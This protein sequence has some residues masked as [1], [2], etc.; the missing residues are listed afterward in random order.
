M[1][2]F[3]WKKIIEQAFQSMIERK[4]KS[5]IVRRFDGKR[6]LVLLSGGILQVDFVKI[7]LVHIS[8]V[9]VIKVLYKDDNIY[10]ALVFMSHEEKTLA[11]QYLRYNNIMPTPKEFFEA[12][13]LQ[14]SMSCEAVEKILHGDMVHS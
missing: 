1:S 12:K 6:N 7:I 10:E 2:N 8:K 4:E 13:S 5:V 3:K 11:V 14:N 9:Y